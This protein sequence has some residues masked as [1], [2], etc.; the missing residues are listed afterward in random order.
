M[1]QRRYPIRF[2]SLMVL[3]CVLF[4]DGPVA[5]APPLLNDL[6]VDPLILEQGSGTQ[7][8]TVSVQASDPD[9]DLKN[10]KVVKRLEDGTK[11]KNA[12]VEDPQAG[13]GRFI[14]QV[15][16]NT[17]QAQQIFIQF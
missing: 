17:D 4:Y 13:D 7:M 11:E 1:R 3:V 10:I 6:V 8:I 5:A 16:V 2:A 14:A 12:L 15:A 9:G